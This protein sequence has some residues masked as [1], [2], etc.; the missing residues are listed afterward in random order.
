MTRKYILKK[1]EALNSHK[2]GRR[3]RTEAEL[4]MKALKDR[5]LYKE[6]SEKADQIEAAA[7]MGDSNLLET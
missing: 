4:L 3:Q 5:G 6:V 1:S 2:Q 7:R